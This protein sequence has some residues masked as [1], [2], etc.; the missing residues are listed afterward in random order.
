MKKFLSLYWPLILFFSFWLVYFAL[1]WS[2]GVYYDAAG[3]L[4]AGHVNIWGD[5]AAH[6]TMGNAMAVRGLFIK[7]PFLLNANFSYPFV[8]DYIS[9][10]LV[11]IGVPF[12]TAFLFPSFV[13]SILIVVALYYFYK[14]LFQSR[15]ISLIATCIFL[16][17]GGV[18]FYYFFQDIAQSSQPLQTFLIPLHEYTR[19]DEQGIK[20]ISV[21]DSMIIPQRS[22]AMGF[23]CAIL[24]LAFVYKIFF[25]PPQKKRQPQHEYRMLIVIGVLLGFLP[26]LHTHSFLASFIFLT[27]WAV[28]DLFFFASPEKRLEHLKKWSLIAI[29]TSVIALPLMKYYFLHNVSNNFFQW[30]PGWM[31]TDFHENW[32]I[33]TWKNWGITPIL[34]IIGVWVAFKKLKDKKLAILILPSFLI[35]IL[36]N[37]FLFQPWSWD[38]TKLLVWFLLGSSGLISYLLFQFYQLKWDNIA[39]KYLKTLLVVSVFLVVTASGMIDAYRIQLI[40]QHS[41]MMYNS[42]EL[43]LTKW[44]KGNTNPNSIWLTGHQHNHWLFNLTGRQ[45]VMAYPGWLWTQGYDF[46]PAQNNVSAMYLGSATSLE[47]LHQYQVNYVVVGPNEKIE[48]QANQEFFDQ[49][50]PVVYEHGLTKIYQ[51][52]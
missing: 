8:A 13:F 17:N 12:I 36:C 27:C 21:I 28:T 42:E 2:R 26:I 39:L 41:Y 51:V 48:L 47:L 33:F 3:D 9:A 16:F 45:A 50:F 22:F 32:L 19:I 4:W 7:S 43:Q 20:W 14:T 46:F 5:W 23:S 18:G 24:A 29:T 30:Y 34:A 52:K 6:F 1:F 38:N 49:H 25:L 40:D 35:F 37:L 11:Q 15:K 44:V 31:S 10:L